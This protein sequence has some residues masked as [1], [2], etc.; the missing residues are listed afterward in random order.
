MKTFRTVALIFLICT[1]C[2][3]GCGFIPLDFFEE[4]QTGEEETGCVTLYKYRDFQGE[5][6]RVCESEDLLDRDFNDQVSS[7][8]VDCSL[9]AVTFYEHSN[10][11][12]RNMTVGGC[13]EI[14]YVG[15]E[16]DNQISSLILY[17]Q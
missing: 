11:S 17:K 9:R 8:S 2:L 16:F 12:G 13:L 14:D 3:S 5:S 15:H 4:E 6:L 10:F 7:L 1:L